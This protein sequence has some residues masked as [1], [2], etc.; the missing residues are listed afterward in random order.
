MVAYVFGPKKMK[1]MGVVMAEA[2]R[3]PVIH[4]EAE[5]FT[6]FPDGAECAQ[7]RSAPILGWVSAPV[8]VHHPGELKRD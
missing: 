8:L 6:L 1:L 4:E 7:D 2:S 5:E 3:V